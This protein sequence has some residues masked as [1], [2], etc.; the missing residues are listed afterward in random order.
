MSISKTFHGMTGINDGFPVNETFSSGA[1][2]YLGRFLGTNY[3]Y[4]GIN[5]NSL[6]G[7]EAAN[8]LPKSS[9]PPENR[10]DSFINNSVARYGIDPNL[11]KAIIKKESTQ[12]FNIIIN[13]KIQISNF[14]M[15]F[16]VILSNQSKS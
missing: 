14:F 15:Y 4:S 16:I 7:T 11:I 12:I 9:N 13:R 5:G 8:K 3:N 6:S 2:S 1:E 10:F